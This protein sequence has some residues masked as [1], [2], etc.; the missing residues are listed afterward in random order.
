LRQNRRICQG[1]V[2]VFTTKVAGGHI[3]VERKTVGIAVGDVVTCRVLLSALLTE[4]D[5]NCIAVNVSL[6][7]KRALDSTLNK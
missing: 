7:G 4:V 2:F 3:D 5:G 1:K 6:T